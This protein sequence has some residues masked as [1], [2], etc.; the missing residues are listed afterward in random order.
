MT[1]D[2]PDA[3]GRGGA[4]LCLGNVS[5]LNARP[6]VWGLE[7]HT[8]LVIV[9]DV[10]SRLLEGVA[11][12]HYDVA[13]LPAIDYQR[14]DDLCVVPAGGI[15][16]DGATLTVRIFS[17][18]PLEEI[19]SLAFDGDSH[20]SVALACI[21]LAERCGRRPQLVEISSP[22]AEACDARLLIGD[23]VVSRRHDGYRCEFDL[24]VLWKEHTGLPFL[25][26]VW[27]TRRGRDL[28]DLPLRLSR[29]REEGLKNV[30][31]IVARDAGGR[32][33]PADLARTYLSTLMKYEVGPA[34]LQAMALFHALAARH[35]L[36][37]RPP[38]EIL[39][40]GEHG[41]AFSGL[42]RTAG[43]AP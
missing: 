9:H 24:G 19:S 32:G 35:G 26:A 6:L 37:A 14:R 2:T 15:G 13:L 18:K 27:M 4:T 28:R 7:N 39:L 8:D 36:L 25:F 10:P 29:A 1:N 43:G 12:G 30:D 31:A 41:A 38:R 23:K 5:F 40:Y 20:T 16:C 33:W 17:R 11:A 42:R 3:H 34:Q 21:L 22:R